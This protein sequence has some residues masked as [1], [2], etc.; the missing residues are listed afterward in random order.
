MLEALS[1]HRVV[2]FD[3]DTR[4]AVVELV[5]FEQAPGLVDREHQFGD[6]ASVARVQCR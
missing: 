3:V 2:Q 4:I 5:A 1:L 6:R